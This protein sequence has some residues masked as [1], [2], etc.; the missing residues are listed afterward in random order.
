M[1]GFCT[2]PCD[3]VVALTVEQAVDSFLE[4]RRLKNV[5]ARTLT[6]YAADFRVWQRWRASHSLSSLLL[7][8]SIEELRGFFAY[9]R[10]EHIPYSTN[11][12]RATAARPGLSPH[13]IHG[14]WRLL[15][16]AWTFWTDEELLSDRQMAFFVRGRVPGPKVPQDIRPT[17]DPVLIEALL[18]ADGP[19]PRALSIARDRVV[20][21]LL[22][23]TGMRVSELCG[24]RDADMRHAERHAK[25]CG[26]GDKRRFV[27]NS[28]SMHRSP[29]RS[30]R[31]K[32]SPWR[33]M[34][35]VSNEHFLMCGRP[36]RLLHA[37]S[38]PWRRRSSTG[39]TLGRLLNILLKRSK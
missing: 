28:I 3:Y 33:K 13:T 25:V 5:S 22:Y 1:A 17:Y 24:L 4:V 19:K 34:D 38:R 7:D 35:T 9:L 29:M 8:V 2:P 20:I 11:P 26:K 36:M 6:R 12:F 23:D 18:A 37:F 10:D 27:W 39:R 15:H 31:L 14:H 21:L 30:S 32:K 16:A